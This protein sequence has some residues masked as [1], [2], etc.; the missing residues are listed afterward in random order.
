M[1][2][3]N[4]IVNRL[5]DNSIITSNYITYSYKVTYHYEE[6]NPYDIYIYENFDD[7]T[8]IHFHTLDLKKTLDDFVLEEVIIKKR[9]IY[10]VVYQHEE[11][12]KDYTQNIAYHI[13]STD[14]RSNILH[15]GLKAN[16][17]CNKEVLLTSCYLDS[18]K[19]KNIP[20]N[21]FRSACLYLYKNFSFYELGL[22][23]NVRNREDLYA[24]DIEDIDWRIASEGLSGFC[25]YFEE[26]NYN[27]WL[28]S[29]N[30][31]KYSKK[32]WKNCF[33]KEE[34][35]NKNKKSVKADEGWGLDELLVM[36]DFDKSKVDLIGTFTSN[37]FVFYESFRKYVKD[38]YKD[39]FLEL[40]KKV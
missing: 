36:N 30:L 40:L 20:D 17:N 37:G 27:E 25:L 39:T 11:I 7:E 9:K 23:E 29:E 15:N 8:V 14:N 16:G 28:N 12:L 18:H 4:R 13:S 1:L 24:V 33:S 6:N 5:F 34:Y 22:D 38:E 10:G 2:T 32:Y 19:T 21:F 26:D 3:F 35:L 31:K